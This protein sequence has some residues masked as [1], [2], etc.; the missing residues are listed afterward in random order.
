MIKLLST[1]IGKGVPFY[2]E[3]YYKS[4]PIIKYIQ[5]SLVSTVDGFNYNKTISDTQC[6]TLGTCETDHKEPNS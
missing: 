3:L 6:S 2:T 1:A 5:D 4:L